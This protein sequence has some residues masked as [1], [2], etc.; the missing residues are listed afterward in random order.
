MDPINR[1]QPQ[2]AILRAHE[3][4]QGKAVGQRLFSLE[5]T[6]ARGTCGAGVAVHGGTLLP[7]PPKM[8]MTVNHH[9]EK[10]GSQRFSHAVIVHH[11][12]VGSI[13]PS[14]PEGVDLLGKGS[15]F[16]RGSW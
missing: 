8:G 4:E 9:R 14:G 10:A 5:T 7:D 12:N 15:Q 2:A 1:L 11:E 16:P 6:D 13:W 3:V